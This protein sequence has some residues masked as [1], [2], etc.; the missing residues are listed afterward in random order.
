MSIILVGL[1][2]KSSPLEIREKVSLSRNQI[3]QISKKLKSARSIFGSAILSTCNRT[4]FYLNVGSAVLGLNEA[5]EIIS[6]K[7]GILVDELESYLYVKKNKDA[8][9]HLFFVAAGLDSMILG[10]SQIQGQVQDAYEIALDAE[11]SDSIINTLFMNALTVGKRVRTETQIDRESVSISSAAVSL[12]KRFYNGLEDKVVLVLGAGETSELTTRHLISNG[13]KNFIVANRTYARAEKLANEL[14]GM[15]IRFDALFEYIDYADIIISSTASPKYLLTKDLLNSY[16]VNRKKELLLIDIAIPRD[17]SPELEDYSCITLYDIDDLKD[18]VSTT[19]KR[20][21]K[22]AEVAKKIVQEELENFFFWLD[23]L[24]VVPTIIKM[25]EQIAKIKEQEIEKAKNRI[26][27]IT[28]RELQIIERL[29][30]GIVNQWLHQ[31]I[32]NLKYLAGKKMDEV[33]CYIRAINDLW[34]LD[35]EVNDENNN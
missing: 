22:E 2:H 5:I 23:S 18:V 6:N 25:R 35:V 13:I 9:Q 14:G 31:P 29:A 11:I 7:S 33:D 34:N 8:V 28:P 19:L 12:A 1:N 17:I 21:H 3:F 20:R 24:T 4:E 30:N 16:L 32:I 26:N 10:E 15:A 27:N